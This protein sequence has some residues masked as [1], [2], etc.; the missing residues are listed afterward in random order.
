MLRIFTLLLLISSQAFSQSL[1]MT[2]T[3]QSDA[4]VSIQQ[5]RHR[6]QSFDPTKSM[7]EKKYSTEPLASGHNYPISGYSPANGDPTYWHSLTHPRNFNSYKFIEHPVDFYEKTREQYK[8]ETIF[9]INDYNG[10]WRGCNHDENEFGRQINDPQNHI[11]DGNDRNRV[12]W[13]AHKS[14]DA[15]VEY[16]H[17]GD[18]QS[19]EVSRIIGHRLLEFAKEIKNTKGGKFLKVED[20]VQRLI[21]ANN[22]NIIDNPYSRDLSKLVT[23]WGEDILKIGVSFSPL[24]W[25][26][27]I[28]G[29]STGRDV[30]D[31]HE[32]TSLEYGIAV[33]SA[34]TFGFGGKV[35]KA[36]TVF[37]KLAKK[38]DKL[39]AGIF[40]RKQISEIKDTLI[41]FKK[42]SFWKQ[43]DQKFADFVTSFE[44]KS[45]KTT[46][47]TED[48]VVYRYYNVDPANPTNPRAK[49]T[50]THLYNDPEQAL[51][52]KDPGDYI[53]K[54]WV[55]PKGTE[56][57]EGI[58]APKFGKAGGG[59]QIF[60]PNENVLKEVVR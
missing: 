1:V 17:A 12:K 2:K 48:K 31:N 50:T 41:F 25:L 7:P 54:T 51:S 11:Y 44:M 9:E 52:L 57:L 40:A 24:G 6:N 27:D 36:A 39:P 37:Q 21:A 28:Y 18:M 43:N 5:R 4:P 34:S 32:L 33:V 47:L 13:V 26:E 22:A 10:L 59:Y 15:M 8:F 45:T 20:D 29:A 23:E 58:A 49:W 16:A 19:A 35:V 42:H 3:S 30:W 60:V 55:I 14:F 56:V 53:S 38:A 46:V